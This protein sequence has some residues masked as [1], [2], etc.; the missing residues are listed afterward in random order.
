M[1]TVAMDLS[2]AF[3]CMPHGLLIAK[4]SAYGLSTDA[5]K[6]ISSYLRDRHK[7]I[8]LRSSLVS[9]VNGALYIEVCLKVK[10]ISY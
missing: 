2:K 7:R 6:L 9:L 3:D 1:G 8:K 4:L 10:Y 5:C